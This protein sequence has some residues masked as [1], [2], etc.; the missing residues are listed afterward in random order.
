MTKAIIRVQG[1]PSVGIAHQWYNV[2]N[3]EL[4]DQEH[5]TDVALALRECFARIT[6][7]HINGVTVRFVNAEIEAAEKALDEMRGISWKDGILT[8]TYLNEQRN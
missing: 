1:D 6:G 5:A 8:D 4:L 7:E 3:I 2:D